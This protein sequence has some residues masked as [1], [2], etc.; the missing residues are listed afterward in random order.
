MRSGVIS[1]PP[2]T[3][4]IPTRK[5]TKKPDRTKRGWMVSNRAISFQ[6]I[7]WVGAAIKHKAG[8]NTKQAQ[9]CTVAGQQRDA[10]LGNWAANIGFLTPAAPFPGAGHVAATAGSPNFNRE[11]RFFR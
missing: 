8:P 7:L 6:N 3:P 4:V 9:V 10:I 5:P 11:F 1:E 2:P